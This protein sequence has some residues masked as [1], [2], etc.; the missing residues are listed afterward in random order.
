MCCE[1]V[2]AKQIPVKVVLSDYHN[3]AQ[4]VLVDW[5]GGNVSISSISSY[6]C[7][8]DT[9]AWIDTDRFTDTIMQTCLKFMC[10]IHRLDLFK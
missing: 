9:D 5:R 8:L 3:E 7:E 10:H 2:S 1:T 6:N 4:E